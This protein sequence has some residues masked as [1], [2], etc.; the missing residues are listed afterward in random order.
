MN[1][2]TNK[3]TNEQT[4]THTHTNTPTNK[5]LPAVVRHSGAGFSPDPFWVSVLGVSRQISVARHIIQEPAAKFSQTF[6]NC[7]RVVCVPP[8]AGNASWVLRPGWRLGSTGA[9]VDRVEGEGG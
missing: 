4:N 5:T 3:Q 1:E 7:R 6:R 8:A 9:H 2:R